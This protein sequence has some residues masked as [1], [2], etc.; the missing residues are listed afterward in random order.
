[1]KITDAVRLGFLERNGTG[2]FSKQ[3]DGRWFDHDTPGSNYSDTLRQAID[4]AI[5]AVPTSIVSATGSATAAV[6]PKAQP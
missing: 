3:P 2:Q 5:E 4:R 6:T 1:M